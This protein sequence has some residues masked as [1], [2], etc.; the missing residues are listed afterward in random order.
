MPMLAS[1]ANSSALLIRE[2]LTDVQAQSATTIGDLW[3]RRSLS[4]AFE[5]S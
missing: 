2:F 1:N 4:E 5:E 3:F